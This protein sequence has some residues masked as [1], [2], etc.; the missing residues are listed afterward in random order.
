MTTSQEFI[1][2][3]AL[4][5]AG[6]LLAVIFALVAILWAGINKKLDRTEALA[7]ERL[8]TLGHEDRAIRAQ[9]QDILLLLNDQAKSKTASTEKENDQ[10][11][12]MLSESNKMYERNGGTK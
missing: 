3:L 6:G 12:W 9:I 5:M 11:R 8:R 4:Q 10:L 2:T 1:V 7:M